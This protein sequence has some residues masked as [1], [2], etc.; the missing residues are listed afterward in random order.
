MR[1]DKLRYDRSKA[2]VLM[3]ME[4]DYVRQIFDGYKDYE[5]RISPL[6][7]ELY[8][9]KIY[10]YSRNKVKEIPGYVRFSKA[11]CGDVKTII[12]KTGNEKSLARND[13]IAYFGRTFEHCYALKIEEVHRFKKP[14]SFEKIKKVRPDLRVSK[15]YKYI[16][17]TDPLHNLIKEWEKEAE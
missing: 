12:E 7:D 17:P 3:T 6:P 1:C 14:I 10:I 13:I 8:H 2:I 9:E 16:F 11:I 5:F 15:Y 4:H